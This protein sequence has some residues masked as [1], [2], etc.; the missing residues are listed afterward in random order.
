MYKY[1]YIVKGNKARELQKKAGKITGE[2]L[3]KWQLT[4]EKQ[5]PPQRSKVLGKLVYFQVYAVDMTHIRHG[6]SQETAVQ[7]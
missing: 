3:R 5:N 6:I 7:L 4:G 1:T 2:W